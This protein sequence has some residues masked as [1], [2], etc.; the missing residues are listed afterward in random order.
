MPSINLCM[1]EYVMSYC[2]IVI[3]FKVIDF[4]DV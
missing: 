4:A 3:K 2:L 1:D